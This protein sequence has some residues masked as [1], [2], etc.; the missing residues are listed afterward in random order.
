[1]PTRTGRSARDITA[2]APVA[3]LAGL[4]GLDTA[5]RFVKS[6]WRESLLVF[7]VAA[8]AAAGAVL[9]AAVSG[10]QAVAQVRGGQGGFKG[11]CG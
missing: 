5:A 1:M 3:A 4:A 11:V 6:S 2:F 10:P 7:L 8:V 9:T